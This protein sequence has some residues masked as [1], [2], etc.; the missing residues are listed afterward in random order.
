MLCCCFF[1][2]STIY[3]FITTRHH[4]YLSQTKHTHIHKRFPYISTH[5]LSAYSSLSIHIHSRMNMHTHPYLF[6]HTH[7]RMKALLDRGADVDALDNRGRTPLFYACRSVDEGAISLLL[8]H[9]A[10]IGIKTQPLPWGERQTEGSVYNEFVLNKDIKK[11]ETNT[12][13]NNSN[14]NN[15]NGKKKKKINI[16]AHRENVNFEYRSGNIKHVTKSKGDL[17]F[18]DDFGVIKGQGTGVCINACKYKD[19][20]YVYDLIANGCEEEEVRAMHATLISR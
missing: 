12:S 9:N 5:T 13:E 15:N 8:A 14:K 10:N 18:H 7:S 19:R 6:T 1:I 20:S 11:E 3:D 16:D 17:L 4:L 2:T